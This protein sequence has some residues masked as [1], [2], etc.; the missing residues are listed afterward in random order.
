MVGV[1]PLIPGRSQWSYI[2]NSTQQFFLKA[3]GTMKTKKIATSLTIGTFVARCVNCLGSL[4]E[5][6]TGIWNYTTSN[7]ELIGR[8]F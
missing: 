4:S 6:F 3:V 5:H 2:F 1:K 8:T 7:N